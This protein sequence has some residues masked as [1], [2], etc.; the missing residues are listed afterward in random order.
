MGKRRVILVGFCIP[1]VAAVALR[2]PRLDPETVSVT[3]SEVTGD[4]M[5]VEY[6]MSRPFEVVLAHGIRNPI[7][8][9]DGPGVHVAESTP[10]REKEAGVIASAYDLLRGEH[11][12]RLSFQRGTSVT[13]DAS[14]DR[15]EL[16]AWLAPDAS[17]VKWLPPSGG[18]RY[19]DGIGNDI[20]HFEESSEQEEYL[21]LYAGTDVRRWV[22]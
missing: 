7:Q 17:G 11:Y 19:G 21:I 20:F 14:G 13:V 10:L 2:W 1:L 3:R 4:R 15:L 18:T 6:R 8:W 5:V 12:I 9:P 16:S 22:K